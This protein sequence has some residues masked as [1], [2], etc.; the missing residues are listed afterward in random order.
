MDFEGA[1]RILRVIHP[2]VGQDALRKT[3]NAMDESGDGFL[4]KDEFVRWVKR[5]E[6][7]LPTIEKLLFV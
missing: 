3:F 4:D 7:A 2:D 5:N 1:Q 6:D